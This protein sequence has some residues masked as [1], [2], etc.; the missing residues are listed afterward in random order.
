MS[1]SLPPKSILRCGEQAAQQIHQALTSVIAGRAMATTTYR[2]YEELDAWL[3]P[4]GDRGYPIAYGKFYNIAFSRSE[5][6]NAN[7]V[8][9][10]WVWKT[11]IRLQEA[12]R[13]YVVGRVRNCTIGSITEPDVR[14]AAFASH[15][16]AYDKA[17]LGLVTMVAPEL[18]PVVVAIPYREFTSENYRQTVMQIFETI[19][20]V[21]PQIVGSSLAVLA[22]PGHTGILR[23]AVQRDLQ[24]FRN[25]LALGRELTN[26][27]R[28]IESGTLDYVP[29]IDLVIDRLKSYQF[30][31]EGFAKAAREIIQLAEARRE[32]VIDR[33]GE[34]L[35]HSPSVKQRVDGLFPGLQ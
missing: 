29:L 21:S 35:R 26:L 11:A 15:S 22:G 27:R 19:G 1:L 17:G 31:D 2:F 32:L 34:L 3:G 4:W 18:I 24:E 23:R 12:L 8:T 9:K 20:R 30:P 28:S 14:E 25:E 13:D 16:A 5:K 6:L 10:E 7:P 33:Q